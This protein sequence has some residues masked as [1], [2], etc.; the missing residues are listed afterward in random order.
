M[1]TD[2]KSTPAV[3]PAAALSPSPASPLPASPLPPNPWNALCWVVGT[4]DVGPGCWIGAFTMLD[5]SGGLRIGKG[6]E[7][8]S[9]AQILTHSSMR[10]TVT[11]RA[12]PDVDRAPTELGDHCF[13]GTNATILMGSRIGHHSV[14]A[15]G[16]V[17]KEF[18]DF[19]PFSLIA[20]VPATW[21]R[22]VD[23]D[24][25]R[26]RGPAREPAWHTAAGASSQAEQVDPAQRA[27]QDG[28]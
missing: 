22:R 5:G 4:P 2:V 8:S 7:V 10:R 11:A 18:S 23:I 20:G 9:G 12:W 25:L 26:A 1:A 6:C 17:V 15:A 24:E 21:R 3:A 19:P 14:V 27:G 13:V 16:A 28:A